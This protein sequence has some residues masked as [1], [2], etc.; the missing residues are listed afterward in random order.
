M[1]GIG[2]TRDG[3]AEKPTGASEATQDQQQKASDSPV[4]G[5]VGGGRIVGA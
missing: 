1:Q 5:K 3:D 2:C 4:G